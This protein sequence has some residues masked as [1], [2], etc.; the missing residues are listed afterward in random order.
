MF[1]SSSRYFAPLAG[2]LLLAAC[3]HA[4]PFEPG[5]HLQVLPTNELPPPAGVAKGAVEDYHV[6]PYDKLSVTV[7]GI[8]ELSQKIQADAGAKIALP[9][10][11]SIDASGM[12]LE[13]LSSTIAGRLRGRYVRDPQVAV[14]LEEAVSQTVTVDGQ[15][16][17]P[18]AYPVVGK[19]T[20]MR[21]VALARGTTEYAKLE[22]V[23]VF[24]TVGD[25]EMA[26]LYNLGAIRRG[27]YPDP[28]IYANDIVVVGDSP[29]RRMFTQYLQAASVIVTPI[30]TVLQRL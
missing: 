16:Q 20:L 29:A 5:P 1:K 19:L 21:S 30:I 25:Q 8:P 18:G 10:V 3:A 12:T 17:Q 15:V 23:V 22:D 7:F 13:Q 6:G 4:Q 26:A 27:A 24:R 9:L 14:N 2:V 11:G 28:Q